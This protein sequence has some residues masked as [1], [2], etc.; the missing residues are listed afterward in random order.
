MSQ[1][2]A[3][4]APPRRLL[5]GPGPTMVEP[6]VYQAL[7]Q[8]VVSHL[9]PYFFQVVEDCRELLRQYFA[10]ENAFT[11]AMSGT[12]SAG[13][14]TAVANFVE[15]GAKFL[16]LANGYFA[17]RMS[18]MGRRQGARVSR[19]ERP[20]G[21]G[22][23]QAEVCEVIRR[24]RPAVVGFVQA[25]TSTG[26][27][28]KSEFICQ[29]AHE[30][31]ALVIADCVTSLGAMPVEVDANGI[32]IAYSCTQKGLSCPPGLAPVTVS[33]RAM[34]WL[35]ARQTTPAD[36]YLD[37]KL[38]ADYYEGAHRYHHTAPISLFYALREGLVAIAEEGFDA[39]L[40]R[41]KRAHLAFV[42]GIEAMG[43][44]MLVEEGKRIWN[45][46]TVR[47]P[48]GVDELA[49]RKRLLVASDIEILGGFGPLAG[50]IFRIGIMGPLA[51]EESV[52]LLLGALEQALREE[53]YQVP[54]SGVEAAKEVFDSQPATV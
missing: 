7:N 1:S 30:V 35:K 46:N 31:G 38:L 37:L 33:P 4:L 28:Q 53:G 49:V 14:Q 12:G 40:A 48:P 32:D 10:T 6:R 41:H 45:L 34:E 54:R 43:L 36:W 52:T 51:K 18:E 24:E 2:F 44:S 9:D 42:A 5:F 17:D 3:P 23:D 26:V 13:M 21:Q 22:F 16:V 27:Y 39:R 47:V 11:L 20:W 19:L 8:P 29:A 50:Q 15:P 25:E